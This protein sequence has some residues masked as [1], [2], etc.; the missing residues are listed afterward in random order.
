MSKTFKTVGI[1]VGVVLVIIAAI[2]VWGF[3]PG[4]TKDLQR[5]ADQF[6]PE[7]SWTLESESVRPYRAICLDGGCDELSK[8]WTLVNAIT[9]KTSFQSI[10]V[11]DNQKLAVKPDCFIN[12]Y[13]NEPTQL[14][15]DASLA[16]DGYVVTLSYRHY[17][18]S[19]PVVTLNIIR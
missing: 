6:M 18:G 13:T 19:A 16:I 5:I 9:D 12:T 4:S 15:C 11:V 17:D 7:S 10:A 1:A 14:A 3:M 8:R 2:V